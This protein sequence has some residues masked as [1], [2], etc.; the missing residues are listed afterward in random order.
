MHNE[1]I[2]T[3]TEVVNQL[4]REAFDSNNTELKPEDIAFKVVDKHFM[5]NSCGNGNILVAIARTVL[6]IGYET[7]KNDSAKAY[8]QIQNLVR[9][10]HGIDINEEFVQECK[11]RLT[12]VVNEFYPLGENIVIADLTEQWDIKC[13]DS[14]SCHDYDGKMDY[15]IAN[16][17]YCR[18]H[19]FGENKEDYKATRFTQESN[20]DLYLAFFDAGLRM[21]KDDGVMTYITPSSWLWSKAGRSFRDYLNETKTLRSYYDFGHT[22]VFPKV[23]TFVGITTID[24]SKHS[25]DFLLTQKIEDTTITSRLS[26]TKC[27]AN[28]RIWWSTPLIQNVEETYDCIQNICNYDGMKTVFVKNGFATLNDKL[29]LT[30]LDNEDTIPVMKLSKGQ[31]GKMVFPYDGNRPKEFDELN[32]D[33]QQELLS[34]IGE[35]KRDTN[36]QWHLYGRTQAIND[37]DRDKLGIGTLMSPDGEIKQHFIPQGSGCYSGLYIILNDKA[38]ENAN[39]N[40]EDMFSII[41]RL[42]SEPEFKMYVKTIGRYKSGGYYT[43]TSKEIERYLNYKFNTNVVNKI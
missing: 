4:L 1:T 21:L 41:Q 16:P 37:V 13:A 3:P 33:T 9:C 35:E 25:D 15:V 10:L 23:T 14:L 24:N 42:L 28:G 20:T 40:K 8:C 27:M 12:E 30:D 31:Q 6:S 5:D 26:Y 18:A 34:K 43:Y 2:F 36:P 7:C 32:E 39:Y 17:P 22:Q 38:L 11:K 19:H 29:F